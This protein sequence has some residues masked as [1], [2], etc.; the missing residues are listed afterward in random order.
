[1][2]WADPE[3]GL[4]EPVIVSDSAGFVSDAGATK[5]HQFDD[6]EAIAETEEIK[7]NIFLKVF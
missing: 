7:V 6:L 1:V 2:A 5:D 3:K 4:G